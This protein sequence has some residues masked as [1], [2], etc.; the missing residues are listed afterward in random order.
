MPRKYTHR[1]EKNYDN[2]INY[3]KCIRRQEMEKNY[4]RGKSDDPQ[5]YRRD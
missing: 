2:S 1:K 3:I 4:E 5:A